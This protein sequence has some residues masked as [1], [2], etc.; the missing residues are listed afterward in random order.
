MSQL[1]LQTLQEHLLASEE[2][3]KESLIGCKSLSQID[4]HT[5]SQIKG[6]ILALRQIKDIKNFLE[7]ELDRLD[8][9]IQE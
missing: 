2:E 7:P 6:Q 9:E 3:F 5:Y 8:E 1:L 4:L